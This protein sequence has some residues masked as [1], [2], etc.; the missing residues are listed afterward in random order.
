MTR[1]H[2]KLEQ[3][4]G[5]TSISEDFEDNDDEKYSSTVRYWKDGKL[6][7]AFQ[8][9]LDAIEIIGTS[10]L[11]ENCKDVEKSKVLEARKE[12]FGSDFEYYPPWKLR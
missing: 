3:V 11:T 4:D 12:A 10:N 2:P 5:S 8:S 6:G 7:T 9:Y 1:K